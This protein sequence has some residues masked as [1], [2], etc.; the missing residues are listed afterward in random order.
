MHCGKPCMNTRTRDLDIGDWI[1]HRIFVQNMSDIDRKT[2]MELPS[3][4][5]EPQWIPV[6]ER[7][8]KVRQWV[9]CQC[10]A[11]IIDVLRLTDDG[12]WYRKSNEIYMSGFVLA[13]MPLPEPYKRG[14]Q[15][16]DQEE[17]S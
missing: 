12:C 7:L 2:I 16:E 13:W 6:S 15:D 5:P 3:A 1:E 10:R 4:Q 17:G 9:L 14:E 11:G 8:P